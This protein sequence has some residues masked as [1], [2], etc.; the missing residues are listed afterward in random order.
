MITA[1]ECINLLDVFGSNVALKID[2]C[3]AFFDTLN[4]DFFNV[5]ENFGLVGFCYCEVG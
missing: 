3:K 4:W 5:L 2:I 1:S